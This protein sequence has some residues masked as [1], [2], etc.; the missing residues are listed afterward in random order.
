[1][2]DGF[3][4]RFLAAVGGDEAALA[5]WCAGP[6][7]SAGLAV[8]RNTTAK[9]AADALAAQFPTVERVVGPAWLAAAAVAHAA[10]HPP[11]T[12]SLLTYG[13]AFGGWLTTFP[14]AA[15]MP[16]LA[17]LAR[18]DWLWT[19]AHLAADAPPLEATALARLTPESFARYRLVLHPATRFAGFDDGAPSLWQ[20]LQPPGDPPADL[21]LGDAPEGLV[22]V[23][24]GLDIDHR[25]I[26]AGTLAFLAGCGAGESLAAAAMDALAAEPGLDLSTVFAGLVAAGAFTELRTLS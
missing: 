20:A 9:G 2:P 23:R 1:M 14:P 25:V 11:R 16:F 6:A 8:Y 10:D 5:P 18:L 7:A 21:E 19:G 4:D 15:D 22:F 26:G 12:A 3:H 13:E 17:D 24:P